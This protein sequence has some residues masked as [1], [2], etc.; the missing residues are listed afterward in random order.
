MKRIFILG[1]EQE[2]H[3]NHEVFSSVN[4]NGREFHTQEELVDF[5]RREIPNLFILALELASRT[6]AA[7]Q[8]LKRDSLLNTVA[9]LA[10]YPQFMGSAQARG[11][12]CGANEVLNFPIE[13]RE[14]LAK[15]ATLLNIDKRRTFKTLVTIEHDRSTVVGRTEDFSTAGISFVAG[16]D[17][18]EK[19]GIL[20]Q[21]FL[22]GNGE[23]IRLQ[24]VV[25][26]KISLPEK[27]FFYGARFENVDRV[28]GQKIQNFIDRVK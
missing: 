18:Q 8:Q 28:V 11:R 3:L 19:D 12:A 2:T 26:R 27:K 14:L 9:I 7:I 21:F 13:R 5:A 25:M 10:Y 17:F 16:D 4:A 23:R 1:R 22:P 20:L 15:C 6:D 24:A